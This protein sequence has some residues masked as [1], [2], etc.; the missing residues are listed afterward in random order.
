MTLESKK[1]KGHQ[2]KFRMFTQIYPID[3]IG[4]CAV[5]KLV[6]VSMDLVKTNYLKYY[7]FTNHIYLV[8]GTKRQRIKR[9]DKLTSLFLMAFFIVSF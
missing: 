3:P 7:N 5:L 6:R 9:S 1:E 4:H 8:R 2:N